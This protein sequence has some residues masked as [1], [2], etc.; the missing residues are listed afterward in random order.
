MFGTYVK[1]VAGFL[2]V[3]AFSCAVVLCLAWAFAPRHDL[4]LV[5]RPAEARTLEAPSTAVSASAPTVT[6]EPVAALVVTTPPVP[7]TQPAVSAPS[8]YGVPLRGSG[9]PSEP[10]KLRVIGDSLT[11]GARATWERIKPPVATVVSVDARSGRPT[12]E[13]VRI[14]RD[15][16]LNAGETLVFALGTN[17]S[18]RY[19]AFK[20]LIDEVMAEAGPTNL[21]V[22][23]T[24]WRKGPSSEINRALWDAMKRYQNL[25]VLEWTAE[26]TAHPE[27]LASDNVHYGRTGYEAMVQFIL[28]RTPRS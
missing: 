10:V 8:M 26:L 7:A 5:S 15:H 1:K 27:Y 19:E 22:W 25:R 28:E 9:G 14:L 2:G 11:V 6:S 24:V 13:G 16:P 20:A 4:S 3:S 21:V 18:N 23:P 12:R 17:D